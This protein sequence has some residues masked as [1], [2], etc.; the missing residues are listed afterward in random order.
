VPSNEIAK[1]SVAHHPK[2][3]FNAAQVPVAGC[4]VELRANQTVRRS[5]KSGR[6]LDSIINCI[7]VEQVYRWQ[8]SAS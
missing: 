7:L 4:D 2:P 5:Y 6:P 1:S 3:V 8:V